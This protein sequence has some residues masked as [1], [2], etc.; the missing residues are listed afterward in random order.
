MSHILPSVE[1]AAAELARGALVSLPTETVYGLAACAWD[2]HAV[3]QIFRTKQRPA[4]DPLIVHVADPAD[5]KHV[6]ATTAGHGWGDICETLAHTFWPGPLTVVIEKARWVD[7]VITAGLGT[8]GIRVPDHADTRAVIRA[9]NADKDPREGVGVAMPSANLF[10]MTSPTSA[11]HVLDAFSSV[12]VGVLDGG[13][14]TR[15]IESTVVRVREQSSE[16][17]ASVTVLRPGLIT[18]NELKDA[19]GSV[20][21]QVAARH[22]RGASPGSTARHYAPPVPLV[23]VECV[24]Q[25][26]VEQLQAA[27]HSAL[28][29]DVSAHVGVLELGDDPYE[30]ARILYEGLRRVALNAACVVVPRLRSHTDG[31]HNDGGAWDAI[32]D[33]IERA[34]DIT[35]DVDQV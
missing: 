16:D 23:I 13:A 9:V 2:A 20:S 35:V 8:V 19:I 29:L 22:D 14:C 26:S 1:R 33:R 11:Q 7:P 30:T 15:G 34:A 5:A 28:R 21:V 6:A 3:S 31:M 25:A 32:W 4:F 17:T 10:G 24:A 18:V 27:A 12:E